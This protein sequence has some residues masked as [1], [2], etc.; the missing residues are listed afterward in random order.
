MRP[1]ITAIG[2]MFLFV[3]TAAR[4]ATPKLPLKFTERSPLSSAAEQRARGAPAAIAPTMGRDGRII[5]EPDHDLSAETFD[6]YVPSSYSPSTPY[7]LF[8]WMGVTE[9][10]PSWPDILAR[11]RMIVVAPQNMVKNP[12]P[13]AHAGLPVDAVHNMKRRYA[14][15]ADRVY[16]SGFSG[17]GLEAA[18]ELHYYPDVF[19]GAFF[20]NG[21]N[22]YDG[23]WSPQ[24]VLEPSTAEYRRWG[25]PLTYDQLKRSLRIV[26][27]TGENDPVF[28]PDISRMNFAG[29]TLDGFE[30]V[31]YF[32]IPR[33]G[34]NHPDDTWFERAINALDHPPNNRP[35]ATQPTDDRHP[36][37]AQLAQAK[38][39][40]AQAQEELDTVYPGS[41]GVPRMMQDRARRALEQLI[42]DYPTTPSAETGRQLL[43]WMQ[44]NKTT[45]NGRAH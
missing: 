20:I 31:T 9:I 16:L 15:D 33:G 22:F 4:G 13:L 2:V 35:P 21:E 6:V 24:G 44:R 32:E 45:L 36:N 38:R 40:L 30:H 28:E 8:V 3:V 27:L 5:T 39:L 41:P 25:G 12:N 1:M 37:A 23:H 29:L 11:H 43:D 26:I 19:R 7:G 10:S 17:G 18:D 14:I 42:K 34:H